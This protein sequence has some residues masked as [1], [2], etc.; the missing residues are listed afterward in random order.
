MSSNPGVDVECPRFRSSLSE[1]S[2]GLRWCTL[3]KDLISSTEHV[4]RLHHLFL[5][6]AE[7]WIRTCFREQS[8]RCEA[9]IKIKKKERRK[10]ILLSLLYHAWFNVTY[11][12]KKKSY[13]LLKKHMISKQSCTQGSPQKFDLCSQPY[14]VFLMTLS[15]ALKILLAA[16]VCVAWWDV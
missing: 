4:W 9:Q 2:W 10:K 8:G 1:R 16:S 11:S 12:I 15:K 3:P 14:Y 7:E 6:K 5:I 13:T